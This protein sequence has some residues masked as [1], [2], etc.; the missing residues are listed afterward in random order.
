MLLHSP[1][2]DFD[3]TKQRNISLVNSF[4][5]YPEPHYMQYLTRL[6]LWDRWDGVGNKRE[7]GHKRSLGDHLNQHCPIQFLTDVCSKVNNWVQNDCIQYSWVQIFTNASKKGTNTSYAFL[8]S[9]GGCD[10]L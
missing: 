6:L 9:R 10:D 2:L 3:L 8:A 1:S 5:S 7:N 4:L